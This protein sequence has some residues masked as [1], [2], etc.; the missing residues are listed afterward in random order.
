[1]HLASYATYPLLVLLVLLRAPARLVAARLDWFGLLP[2]EPV[3][4]LSGTLPLG[5][6]Y[7]LAERR[8]AAPGGARRWLFHV[9]AAMA[10]GAGLALGNAVAV[11]EGLLPRGRLFFERTPKRGSSGARSHSYRSPATRLAMLEIL[12]VAYL[13]A[14]KL[15]FTGRT[16]P[17]EIPFLAFF[18][19]GL[20][21][22]SLP[23]LR[24]MRVRASP[25]APGARQ[26]FA[27]P[28]GG[29]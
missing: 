11:V 26:R 27:G 5:L 25:P 9:P 29:P 2:G 21:A 23:S 15:C 3:L 10:L 8:A 12:L 16:R 22:M 6:F 28:G 7:L 17:G 1:M 14:C 24:A 19:F 13:V 18:A 20:L 4:L